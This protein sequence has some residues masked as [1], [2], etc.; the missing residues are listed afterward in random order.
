M[1]D[2][3]F[4]V[5]KGLEA[6]H[7]ITIKWALKHTLITRLIV[8]LRNTFNIF[9]ISK[10]ALLSGY[11]E[12]K[13]Y[14]IN[15]KF[16]PIIYLT[17]LYIRVLFFKKCGCNWK[18]FSWQVSQSCVSPFIICWLPQTPFKEN[19]L[20]RTDCAPAPH[21]RRTSAA[22]KLETRL[23]RASISWSPETQI[24][25]LPNALHGVSGARKE[26]NWGFWWRKVR[27]FRYFYFKNGNFLMI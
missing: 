27:A 20:N 4:Q 12:K 17:L 7:K 23:N 26:A 9:N 24:T 22:R 10:I 19:R 2:K 6:L 21:G 13:I 15:D 25:T 14:M 16:A 1:N 18:M 5:L 3:K 8:I 11:L